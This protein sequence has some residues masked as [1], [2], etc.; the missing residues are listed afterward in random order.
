MRNRSVREGWTLL[1]AR[2]LGLDYRPACAV[3]EPMLRAAEASWKLPPETHSMAGEG[4]DP[5]NARYVYT[6]VWKV[7]R[8]RGQ[9]SRPLRL[10]PAPGLRML[11][12]FGGRGLAVLPQ[13]PPRCVPPRLRGLAIVGRSL[14]AHRAGVRLLVATGLRVEELERMMS[15]GHVAWC[16]LDRLEE[17]LCS[18]ER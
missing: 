13:R 4:L 1:G 8:R 10:E 18:L 16:T 17:M 6:K 15:A 12:P 14:A 2:A 11:L 3:P 9:Y 7:L 5:R